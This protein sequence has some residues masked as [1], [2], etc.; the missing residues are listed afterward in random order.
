MQQNQE[1]RKQIGLSRL[2]MWEVAQKIGISDSTFSK[3]LR[4]PLNDERRKRVEKAIDE[5]TKVK[6]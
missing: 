5:L 1:V 6:E 3:W 4:I 2:K